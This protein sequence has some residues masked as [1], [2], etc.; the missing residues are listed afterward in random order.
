[1]TV[2]QQLPPSNKKEKR[3]ACTQTNNTKPSNKQPSWKPKKEVHH[4]PRQEV[5]Y[6]DCLS[7]QA[8]TEIT[9]QFRLFRLT[10]L[11][12]YE[13]GAII[14]DLGFSCLVMM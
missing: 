7:H 9:H 3:R 11:P 1:M 8:R 13:D 5:H 12:N 14:F 2:K 4:V 6:V 10:A